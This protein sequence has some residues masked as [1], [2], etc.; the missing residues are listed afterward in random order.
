M[1]ELEPAFALEEMRV[2]G[3]LALNWLAT[4]VRWDEGGI[5]AH[6]TR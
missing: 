2:N 5:I 6:L 3:W 4:S 1:C